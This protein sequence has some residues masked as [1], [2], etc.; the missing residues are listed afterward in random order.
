MRIAIHQT[1][2]DAGLYKESHDTF[3]KYCRERWGWSKRH[4]NRQVE[5]ANTAEILTPV[6]VIPN[7]RVARELAPLKGD[8]ETMNRVWGGVVNEYGETPASLRDS[9]GRGSKANGAARRDARVRSNRPYPR[10]GEGRPRRSNR[11]SSGQ[12]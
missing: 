3:E 5:A 11:P 4:A 9:S 6:G 8:P 12:S 10:E 7:E 2:S 1:G